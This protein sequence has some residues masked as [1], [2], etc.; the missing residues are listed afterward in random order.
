MQPDEIDY[1]IRLIASEDLPGKHLEV[2][3]A[4]GI[5]LCAMVQAFRSPHDPAF[6]VVDNMRYFPDQIRVIRDNLERFGVDPD[7]IEFRVGDS[8]KVFRKAQEA[9]D[10]FDFMLIDASHRIRNVTADLR[11]TRLLRPGGVVCLHDYHAKFPGVVLSVDRFLVRHQNY[12]RLAQVGSVLALR[13]RAKSAKPEVPVID[14]L[15]AMMWSIVFR[16][17]K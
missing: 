6:V 3:T 7:S 2:G 4:R 5:T 1:L 12:E 10:S 11:W 8:R 9:G 17:R 16:F 14:R 15:W 13:K